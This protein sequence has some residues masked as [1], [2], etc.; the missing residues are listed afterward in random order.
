M[1]G[2]SD[3]PADY[4]RS[5]VPPRLVAALAAGF[6]ICL[7][8]T[9]LVLHLL[10]PQAARRMAADIHWAQVPGP[11]LQINPNQEFAD[12]RHAE[13]KRLSTYAWSDREH[14]RVRLPIDRAM[15]VILEQGLPG[16]RRP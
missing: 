1:P 7:I 10:Y 12:F 9:P 11:R 2:A 16:W 6:A 4:E 5:D 15:S 8:L 13:D 14:T 3:K